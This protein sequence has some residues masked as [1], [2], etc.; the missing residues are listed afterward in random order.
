MWWHKTTL[1][2]RPVGVST[3]LYDLYQFK[4]A[5]KPS[6]ILGNEATLLP[7]TKAWTWHQQEVVVVPF[8]SKI[9]Y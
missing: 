7:E 9:C 3:I 8:L 6:F 1:V 4:N 2:A 5:T